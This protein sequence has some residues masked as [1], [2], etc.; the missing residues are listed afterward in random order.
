MVLEGEVVHRVAVVAAEPVVP[1]V[2]VAAELRRPV[3]GSDVRVGPDAKIPAAGPHLARSCEL[4]LAAAVAV[5]A[6]KPV[7]QAPDQAVDAMLLIAFLEAAV[8]DLALVGPAVAVGVLGVKNFRR[9]RDEHALAQGAHRSE[10]RDRQETRATCRSAVAVDV[11]ETRTV[12]PGLPLPS[13]P[14]G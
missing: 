4:D 11:L 14:S 1:V 13:R 3:C 5:G 12:P 9:T 7:V 8:Q 6:V 2:A 10:N